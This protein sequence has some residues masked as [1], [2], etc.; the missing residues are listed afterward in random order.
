M[1]KSLLLPIGLAGAMIGGL[2]AA[3]PGQPAPI[4]VTPS[5]ATLKVGESVQLTA[6]QSGA[7]WTISDPLVAT[8]TNSGLVTGRSVGKTVVRAKVKNQF[9][10]SVITVVDTAPPPILIGRSADIHCPAG[11]VNVLPGE[12]LNTVV[13]ITTSGT[14]CVQP[15]TVFPTRPLYVRSGVTLMGEYGGAIDCTSVDQSYDRGGID[16]I[17]GHNMPSNSNVTVR[18]LLVKNLPADKAACIGWYQPSGWTVLNNEVV[19]CKQGITMGGGSGGNRIAYNYIHEVVAPYSSYLGHDSVFEFNR[20]EN[21]GI[22]AVSATEPKISGTQNMTLRG[23]IARN[24]HHGAAFWADGDNTGFVFENNDIDGTDGE[25][26][27]AEISA[28]GI[29]RN[30]T[31]RN[32]AVSGVFISTSRNMQVYGNTIVNAK[33]GINLFLYCGIV[34]GPDFPYPGSIGFDLRENDIHDNTVQFTTTG[35]ISATSFS[36]TGDCTST[37]LEPYLTNAKQNNFANDHYFV[38]TVSGTWWF[39]G[40]WK[41]WAQW[42]AIPQDLGGTVQ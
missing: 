24:V 28:Y 3:R 34:G 13:D 35:D 19:N 22:G 40:A 10:E 23:N 39:W 20:F 11:S 25:C 17:S 16:C 26:L 9:G 12:N 4:T 30:N 7:K 2:M 37:F 8:L 36:W 42:Q 21:N 31:C 41:T 32:V 14:I 38:P 1:H 33:R 27:M 15:G 5:A 29:I 6:S 18:N